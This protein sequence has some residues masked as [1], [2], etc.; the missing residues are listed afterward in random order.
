[1]ITRDVETGSAVCV[2]VH[3][4][5]HDG[6]E[7]QEFAPLNLPVFSLIKSIDVKGPRYWDM[8]I[9]LDSLLQNEKDNVTVWVKRKTKYSGS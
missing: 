3:V 5:C 4:V 8:A 6:S 9:P 2:P 7:I 1:M